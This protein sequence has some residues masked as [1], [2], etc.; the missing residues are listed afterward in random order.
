M[1]RR[2]TPPSV[3]GVI[4]MMHVLRIG[5]TSWEA[6]VVGPKHARRLLM[7]DQECRISLEPLEGGAF[8]V[9]V[10]GARFAI[11]LAGTDDRRYLHIEGEV[12]EVAVLDPLTVHAQKEAGA[13]GLRARAPMP[14]SV[15]AYPVCVGATVRAGDTVVVIESMKLEVAIKAERTGTVQTLHVDIGR[16]FEKGAVLVTLSAAGEA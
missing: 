4:D 3:R 11:Y 1:C 13:S 16:T 8:I 15:V 6:A 10:N 5:K 9:K 7:P 14:G 12:F 2:C